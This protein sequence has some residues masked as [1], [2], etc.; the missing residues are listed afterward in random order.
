MTDSVFVFPPGYRL[1]DS[2]TGAPL[3][4]AVIKFYNAGTTTPKTVYADEELATALGTSVTTD[5]LGY[6]TSDG[7][8]KTLIYVGT[9]AYKIVIETAS[10][11]VIATH[12]TIKGAVAVID[13]GD[14]SVVVTRPLVTKSLD[15]TVLAADQSSLFAGNCS[16]GDVTFTLPSAVTVGNGWFVTVQH[17]G[18]A[19]ECFIATVSSQTITEGATSYGTQ[20]C[21]I[22]NGET[23][24]LLSD[25]GNW[26]VS[27]HAMPQFKTGVGVITVADRL[28][29]P[30]AP[31]AGDV[32]IV[33]ATPTGGFSAFAEHDL[34]VYNGAA[35]YKIT[36]PADC[37]WL[38]YVKGE[39]I[40]YR[41]VGSAWVAERATTSVAGT[42]ELATNAEAVT[43]TDTARVAPLSAMRHHP[44]VCKCWGLVTYSG[45]TPTVRASY[46]VTS[47]SDTAEGRLTVTV[48]DDFSSDY[49]AIVVTAE[50]SIGTARTCNVATGGRSAG[51]FQI[52]VMNLGGPSLTDP[53][54]IY[55]A[56]YGTLA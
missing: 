31:A 2:S 54:A 33:T 46:N 10:G 19:N 4:G 35:W 14:L 42:V 49:Y 44:G 32:N 28:S 27:E 11:V 20:M 3:A 9:A 30:S 25:G 51:S 55:F 39:D 8:T 38:A 50:D 34:A 13:P 15:Y 21:L 29:A 45:G 22:R 16:G 12:D 56:C 41:F 24:T 40:Y 37:G 7:S 23:V 17:A 36:P 43:G 1:T 53:N 6:P 26:R 18:S 47:I 48:A 52:Y 5:A